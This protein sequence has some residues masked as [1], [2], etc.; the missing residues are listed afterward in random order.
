MEAAHDWFVGREGAFS[1]IEISAQRAFDSEMG[2]NFIVFLNNR[3]VSSL[4]A[5]YDRLKAV[6][7]G[8]ARIDTEIPA[9]YMNDRL[10]EFES[11]RPTKA[12]MLSS[13]EAMEAR[14]IVQGDSEATYTSGLRE[15]DPSSN[16]A[17]PLEGGKGFDRPAGILRISAS[18]DVTETDIS[19]QPMFHGN[20]RSDGI[21]K[22]WESMLETEVPPVPA[23]TEL[24]D[25]YGDFESD[26]LH[27]AS[28]SV[29]ELLRDRYWRDK[30]MGEM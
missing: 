3:N 12:D 15:A 14:P 2:V 25:R 23:L 4:A 9:F 28:C 30:A 29:H 18:F 27:P 22:V 13:V 11:I 8:Q 10:Q 24:A 7:R 19:R 21:E 16:E 1:D 17:A 6:G 20:L 5:I 26:K